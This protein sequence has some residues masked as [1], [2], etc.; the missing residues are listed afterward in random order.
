M[1]YKKEIYILGL[2]LSVLLVCADFNITEVTFFGF[3]EWLAYE[4][5]TIACMIYCFVHLV[6]EIQ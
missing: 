1:I 2:M 5:L 3:V 4:A 6:E